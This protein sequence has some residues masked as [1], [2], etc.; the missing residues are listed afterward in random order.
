MGAGKPEHS[1]YAGLKSNG[2]LFP[3]YSPNDAPRVAAL[4]SPTASKQFMLPRDRSPLS[5][6]GPNIRRIE[7]RGLQKPSFESRGG[8]RQ[9]AGSPLRMKISNH[10]AVVNG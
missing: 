3:K 7:S 6:L 4:T 1:P 9:G 5:Q 10:A 2:Q 8:N